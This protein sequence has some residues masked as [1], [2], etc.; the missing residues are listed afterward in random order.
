M[1]PGGNFKLAASRRVA[2][3]CTLLLGIML[4]QAVSVRAD[5]KMKLDLPYTNDFTKSAFYFNGTGT[6]SVKYEGQELAAAIDIDFEHPKDGVYGTLVFS[7][8]AREVVARYV[9]TGMENLGDATSKRVVLKGVGGAKGTATANMEFARSTTRNY[10]LF[11]FPNTIPYL[12]G[13]NWLEFDSQLRIAPR[14]KTAEELAQEE[15]AQEYRERQAKQEQADKARKEFREEVYKSLETAVVMLSV[16]FGLVM[17]PRAIRHRKW[18]SLV[19]FTLLAC[20]SSFEPF[21]LLP[22]LPAYF[23]WYFN[24]FNPGVSNQ[25]LKDLF[26]TIFFVACAVLGLL[27]Y[28][29]LGAIALV[30]VVLWIIAGV[31]AALFIYFP[32][33]ERSRCEHCKYYGNHPVV[34]RQFVRQQIVETTT[35]H[36]D[37]DHTEVT[38]REIIEWYRKRYSVK[39]VAHQTFKD[40]RRCE[41]CRE[42]FISY[43]YRTKKL[44]E[45]EY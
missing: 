4:L 31:L 41:K 37:Y 28:L 36:H 23:W 18:L 24:L 20:L 25:R 38:D 13:I 1:K 34:D 39:E 5:D 27:F 19:A 14:E 16:I 21:F 29:L 9:F 10:A 40:F 42:I 8:E 35:E 11:L 32:H 30:F 43:S 33:T 12:D 22:A 2:A 44:S 7:N 15:K 6:A 26:F 3:A 17:L 45:H